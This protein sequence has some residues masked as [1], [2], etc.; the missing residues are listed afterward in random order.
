MVDDKKI[1]LTPAVELSYLKPEEQ[2]LLLDTM[3]SEQATPSLS[4][5]QKMKKMSQEHSLNEDSM[6][7]LM[8]TPKKPECMDLVIPADKIK[9]FFP[10]SY[11]PEQIQT[12]IFKLLER[13]VQR[14]EQDQ[15]R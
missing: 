14:R 4:Q 10:K 2:K 11:T 7:S 9:R 15:S 1:G 3:E 12:V 13:W 5:A 8:M 6:L